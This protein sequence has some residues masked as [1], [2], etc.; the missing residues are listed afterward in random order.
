M[1]N[2]FSQ[3]IKFWMENNMPIT[4]L[5][6]YFKENLH[7]FSYPLSLVIFRYIFIDAN[8]YSFPNQLNLI[9]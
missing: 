7:I 9:T 1:Y 4:S 8:K 3:V 6:S 2:L 5:E